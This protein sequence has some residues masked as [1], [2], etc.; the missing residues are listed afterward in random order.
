[1]L[2]E[3]GKL[4]Q[5]H[6]ED[7]IRVDSCSAQRSNTTGELVVA[8]PKV[9]HTRAM[10]LPMPQLAH[11]SMEQDTRSRNR[12]DKRKAE[13]AAIPKRQADIRVA[14]ENFHAILPC[15]AVAQYADSNEVP[16]L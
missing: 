12:P 13:V 14:I 11:T 3:Q 2:V 15:T 6:L 7:E 10:G 9:V 8:M 4:L 5:L 1:L 16:Q